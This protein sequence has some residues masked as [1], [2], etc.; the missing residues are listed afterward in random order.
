M[1]LGLRMM[2]GIQKSRFKDLFHEDIENIYGDVLN[3]SF[4][5]NLLMEKNN[6]IFL[7]EKGIDLSNVVMSRFLFDN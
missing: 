7:T 4:E 3:Q 2:E 1:F 6:R 5:E